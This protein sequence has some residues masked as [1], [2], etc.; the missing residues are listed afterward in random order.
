[1]DWKITADDLPELEDNVWY[2]IVCTYDGNKNKKCYFDIKIDRRY[3]WWEKV[4]YWVFPR[5][6]PPDHFEIY[7]TQLK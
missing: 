5:M 3:K 1:M 6:K 7:N 2:N 4:L